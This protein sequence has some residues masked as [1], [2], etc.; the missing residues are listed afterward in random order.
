MTGC[1]TSPV[2][3]APRYGLGQAH[4]SIT[5]MTRLTTAALE[6]KTKRN[7]P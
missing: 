3:D 1:K 7:D 6:V 5:A 4:F 2:A